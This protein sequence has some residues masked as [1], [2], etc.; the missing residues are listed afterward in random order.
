MSDDD[1]EPRPALFCKYMRCAYLMILH[2][3]RFVDVSQSERILDRS[4]HYREEAAPHLLGEVQRLQQDEQGPNAD[5]LLLLVHEKVVVRVSFWGDDHIRAS[6]A[7]PL[8]AE[9]AP[10][11]S[12]YEEVRTREAVH[13]LC[14]SEAWQLRAESLNLDVG[15]DTQKSCGSKA[16]Q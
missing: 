6:S 1:Y 15:L 8:E 5:N 3:K 10:A 2:G 13:H 12:D 7:G 11:A 9:S 14:G 16:A 4:F